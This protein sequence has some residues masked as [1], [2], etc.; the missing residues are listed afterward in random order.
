VASSNTDFRLAVGLFDHHKMVK[1]EKRLGVAAQISLLR[2]W[3]FTTINRPNGVLSGMD[4]DDIAI[5]AKWAGDSAEFVEALIALRW[6]DRLQGGVIVVHDWEENNPWV[7]SSDARSEQSTYAAI[8]KHHGRAA[9]DEWR[10]TGRMPSTPKKPRGGNQGGGNGSKSTPKAKGTESK[11]VPDACGAHADSTA[12]ACDGHC[13]QHNSAVP[14]H[15]D[16]CAP[17]P[18]PSPSPKE[19]LSVN[20]NSGGSVQEQTPPPTSPPPGMPTAP[21]K[22]SEVPYIPPSQRKPPQ[23][24]FVSRRPVPGSSPPRLLSQ[25]MPQ[26]QQGLIE[27]YD[28]NHRRPYGN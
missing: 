15:A 8:V 23:A 13:G 19:S 18:S 7:A 14:I 5:A 6:L 16:R 22:Q 11:T 26:F 10:E 17:S 2:L 3:E 28:A 27:A 1:L 9:A 4:T 24:D 12:D 21:P 25:G 20:V